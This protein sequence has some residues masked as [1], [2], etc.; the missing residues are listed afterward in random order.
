MNVPDNG[1]MHLVTFNIK[2]SVMQRSVRQVDSYVAC[3]SYLHQKLFTNENYKNLV[4]FIEGLAAEC[5]A[6][7]EFENIKYSKPK[8]NLIHLAARPY[9]VFSCFYLKEHNFIYLG[10]DKC[11]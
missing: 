4:Y 6:R 8:S 2:F 7:F 3:K 5:C 9:R 10:V 11:F 1:H